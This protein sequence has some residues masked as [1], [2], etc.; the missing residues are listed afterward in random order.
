M[1]SMEYRHRHSNHRSGFTLFELAIVIFLMGILFSILVI[2]ISGL[3]PIYRVR[4]ASRTI[5]ARIEQLRA[6][7]IATGKPLGIRYTFREPGPH[8]Y[9]DIPPA[10]DEYPDEPIESRKLGISKELPDGV[11]FRRIVFPGGRSIEHGQVDL[12]YSAMGNTGSHVLTLQGGTNDH[13]I[14]ISLKFNAITGTIDFSE[15]EGGFETHE[16]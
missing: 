10:P 16:S 7:A 4:S 2:S 8:F 6:L 9:Q 12:I 11:R 5:G 15:G 3:A 1:T 14:L 13:P